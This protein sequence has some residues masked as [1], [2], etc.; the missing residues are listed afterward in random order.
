M[1]ENILPNG[2][3][4]A[5]FIEDVNRLDSEGLMELYG[6]SARTIRRWKQDVRGIGEDIASSFPESPSPQC[7]DYLRL[8]YERLLIIGDC[9]IPDHDPVVFGMAARLADRLGI[10]HLL[11]N[12]DF[13]AMDCFSGWPQENHQS[14]HFR[15]DLDLAIKSIKVFLN[16]FDSVDY[17]IGNHERRLARQTRGQS[18]IGMF[19]EH[20]LDV[21]YSNYSYCELTSGGKEIIICHPEDYSRVPLAVPLK[22]VAVHHKNIL[23]GHTHRGCMGYDPSGNYWIAEGGH[24]RDT[25]RTMY[26]AMKMASNPAWNSGFSLILNGNFY[27]IDKSNFDFW[28]S[29]ITLKR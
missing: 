15:R 24:A 6:R 11:I 16:S 29:S 20:L 17:I 22:L 28:M 26:K 13:M 18:N 23:C 8:E 12:G 27:F 25:T 5:Q 7:L 10:E 19:C 1:R 4:V 9:E 2:I 21:S 14:L 3:A